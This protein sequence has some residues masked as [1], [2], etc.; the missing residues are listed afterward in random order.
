MK[1]CMEVEASSDLILKLDSA[2]LPAAC[3]EWAFMLAV[4]LIVFFVHCW[5]WRQLCV[6][7]LTPPLR[8]ERISGPLSEAG[9]VLEDCERNRQRGPRVTLQFRASGSAAGWSTVRASPGFVSGIP[10][11]RD[12]CL[13]QGLWPFGGKGHS[14][15]L[16]RWHRASAHHLAD[17]GGLRPAGPGNL[18]MCQTVHKT[19]QC[20]GPQTFWGQA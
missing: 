20:L 4:L 1:G 2:A 14:Q 3:E 7:Q 9:S 12:D 8:R 11:A 10:G 15:A 13:F 16:R 18:W 19:P 17:P 5:L 6:A